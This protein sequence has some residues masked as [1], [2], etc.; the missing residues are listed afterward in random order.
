MKRGP[1]LAAIGLVL[2][3]GLL[4]QALAQ[5]Y[6]GQQADGTMVL[7]DVRSASTPELWIAGRAVEPAVAAPAHAAASTRSAKLYVPKLPAHYLPIFQ[8]AARDH[9]VSASLIAAVAAAESAFNPLATSPKGARGLMQ[10]MPDTAKRF[11]V[12]DR[13]SPE[14]SVRGGAAYLHWLSDRFDNDLDRVLAAYNAGERVV[15]RTGGVPPYPET[16]AYVPRVLA[17][18]RHFNAALGTTVA[19]R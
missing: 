6:V 13:L 4:S 8:A 18:L 2:A 1:V 11:H 10:L 15:E 14:Q 5:V 9:G 12:S 3:T 19:A 17:Y 7:S 16:Q